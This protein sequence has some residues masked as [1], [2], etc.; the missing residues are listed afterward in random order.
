VPYLLPRSVELVLNLKTARA[1][2]LTIPPSLLAR[3]SGHRMIDRRRFLLTVKGDG[4]MSEG[5][6]ADGGS[7]VPGEG[8]TLARCPKSR[9]A[10][11]S[12]PASGTME[13]G[14]S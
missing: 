13:E 1:L 10:W 2:G 11:S 12:S 9:A 6:T 7:G 4:V 14:R 8:S 3:R 5:G